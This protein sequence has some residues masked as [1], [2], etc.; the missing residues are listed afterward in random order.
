MGYFPILMKQYSVPF[1]IL[2]IFNHTIAQVPETDK[3]IS[4]LK[5]HI[6]AS[7]NGAKLKWMDSLCNFMHH[8]Q[9]LESDSLFNETISFAVKLDSTDIAWYQLSNQM[10][11]LNNLKAQPDKAFREY[12]TLNKK[13]KRTKDANILAKVYLNLGDAYFFKGSNADAIRYY[14]STRVQAQKAGNLKFL[15]LA[16]LYSGS[17]RGDTGEFAKGSQEIQEAIRVFKKRKDT[18]NLIGANNGLS[19]LY[20]KNSFYKEAEEVR[21]E[22]IAL[23]MK[24]GSHEH[25][26]SFYYN[27]AIDAKKQGMEKE[28]LQNLLNA[29]KVSEGKPF[30]NY[31]AP[32][33]LSALSIT[34]SEQGDI[35]MAE[36]YQDRFEAFIKNYP[37]ERNL[38]LQL[39]MLKFLAF[40]KGD[41]DKASSYGSEHLLLKKNGGNFEEVMNAEKFL[42]DV[43][44][45]HGNNTEAFIHFKEYAKIRDS[46]MGVQNVK[47]LTY[48]QTLYETEKRDVLI[49][50]QDTEIALLDTKNRLKNQWL[51]FGGIGF[52]A[53][54]MGVILLRSRNYAKRNEKQQIHFFQELIKSR[55]TERTRVARELHDSVGQK[56]MLLT[57]KTK[58]QQDKRISA[59]AKETLEELRAISRGLHPVTLE[60]LGLKAAIESLINESDAYSPIFFTYEIDSIDGHLSSEQELHLYRMIQ[61]ALQNILKHSKAKS[62]FIRIQKKSSGMHVIIKDTGKGFDV[63]A[64]SHTQQS[65]GMKTLMERA[66]ILNSKLQISSIPG[67]GTKIEINIPYTNEGE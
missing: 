13:A 2:F 3:V 27:A 17:T 59:L 48:Y 4:S 6:A 64:D 54:F 16:L 15:G 42:S 56:L 14:D 18:F 63:A 19:I 52:F 67:K 20:A 65:L 8:Q 39:E 34:Y 51:L 30:E 7:Q 10:D 46:I 40:A 32:I 47:A 36:E 31:F 61:E 49:K 58:E 33:L 57:R 1:L 11:Y 28:R 29:M 21:E 35:S 22:G 24:A 43:L 23:A 26:I 9:L 53:L 5:Q 38:E 62:A 41:L 50:A 66:A 12:H 37:S 55:E 60:K 44:E 45:K 25:L